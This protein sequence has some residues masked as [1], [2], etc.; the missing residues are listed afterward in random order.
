[1]RGAAASR[2]HVAWLARLHAWRDSPG[3]AGQ[4]SSPAIASDLRTDAGGSV[5]DLVVTLFG[6]IAGAGQVSTA[7]CVANRESHFDPYARNHFSSAAGVF[8]WV[9]ASWRSY[10][11]RYGFT[12][13][14]VFDAYANIAVAAHAVANGGWGPWGGGCW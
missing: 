9:A 12:G 3:V 1:M 14:S 11:S 4:Q 5:R 13:A 6:R 2:R 10:S 8:Q 7:L